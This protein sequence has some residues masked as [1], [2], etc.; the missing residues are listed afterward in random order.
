[1]QK[2]PGEPC[3]AA[4][5]ELGLAIGRRKTADQGEAADAGVHSGGDGLAPEVLSGEVDNE[6]KCESSSIVA[7]I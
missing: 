2:G 1:M 5:E 3:D 6:G 7:E 4:A